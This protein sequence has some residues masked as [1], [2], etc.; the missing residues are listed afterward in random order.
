MLKVLAVNGSPRKNGNVARLLSAAME[1]AREA[2]G[3]VEL[4]NLYD[5]SFKGCVSCFACKR[6]PEPAPRC[7]QQDALTQVLQSAY[8]ADVL[9]IGSPIYFAGLS[10]SLRA[11][12]ERLLYKYPHG[13]G[14]SSYKPVGCFYSMNATEEQA[15]RLNYRTV[16][17]SMEDFL[18]RNF[19]LV[20]TMEAYDTYQ[21]ENYADYR[22]PVDLERKTRQ[23]QLQFPKDLAKARSLGARLT[24]AATARQQKEEPYGK[25]EENRR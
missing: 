23:K 8:Q 16:L 10:S 7:V 6:L 21:F 22:M 12:L 15:E 14:S 18:T 20:E 19:Q 5:L 1:G 13:E 17:W 4:V 3:E 24:E 25:S 9:L 11:F 2:G